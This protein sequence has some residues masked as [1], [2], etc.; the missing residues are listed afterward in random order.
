MKKG[1]VLI[2]FGEYKVGGYIKAPTNLM[3][4]LQ[5]EGYVEVCSDEPETVVEK[6]RKNSK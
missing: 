5:A 3:L 2:S 1:K 4:D 6:K